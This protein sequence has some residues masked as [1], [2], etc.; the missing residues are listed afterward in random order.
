MWSDNEAKIDLLNI[1][2]L[3]SGVTSIVHN[4]QLSPVTIGVFGDWGSGKSSILRMVHKELESEED[5][6]CVSFNG[7]LFEGYEDAK[8]ALMG[9]ILEELK[10]KG[11]LG[12]KAL[13]LASKLIKRVNWF[14]VLGLAGKGILT[15]STGIPA[16]T[17]SDIKEALK[18]T[19]DV[20]PEKI[21]DLDLDQVEKVLKAAPEE[22]ARQ[23]IREFH[24]DFEELIKQSK[25]K[26]LVVFIDDLDRCLP[27]TVIDTL[28]AIRLFLYVPNTVF[29]IAADEDLVRHAVEARFPE[30]QD[31]NRNVGRDY[32]EKLVQVP[33]RLPPLGHT[34]ME[35]YMSLLFIQLHLSE[36]YFSELIEQ[37]LNNSEDSDQKYNYGFYGEAIERLGDTLTSELENDLTLVEQIADVLTRGFAG[38]PRQAKRFLNTLLLRMTMAKA[39][40]KELQKRVLAKLMLLEYFE[41]EIFRKL[42]EWQ[43]I[44]DG[45]PKE[46]TLLE[47][48]VKN[49][50]NVENI[51]GEA[52]DNTNQ[53]KEE[54]I[55]QDEDYELPQY[56]EPWLN[57]SWLFEWLS[58][59]PELTNV[60]LRPYFHIAR[61]RLN[62]Q[63]TPASRL[64]QSAQNVL[65]ALISPSSAER[66]NG[67]KASVELQ[68]IEIAVLTQELLQRI[69]RTENLST[70][71]PPLAGLIEFLASHQDRIP[72][73]VRTLR[74]LNNSRIPPGLSPA[75]VTLSENTS[76]K[77][78]VRD[79][80]KEWAS[81]SVG[82][83]AKSASLVLNRINNGNI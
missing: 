43:G 44:Q 37:L 9:T 23:T 12:R 68:E 21:K 76:H 10:S 54:D 60:D 16:F 74:I 70:T 3:V 6:L 83:L 50:T 18:S 39:Q 30:M 79:L 45:K 33:F 14:R 78:L 5:V 67:I 20:D 11:K 59:S 36:E 58:S 81:S 82:P 49:S 80:L 15:F 28:E 17:P 57:S 35:R 51:T 7:W 56:L 19:G 75:L 2:H 42:S 71:E 4:D 61:E 13:N 47:R 73:A 77:A 65:S 38:N 64:S 63:S 22:S 69:R 40:K 8:A 72:D 46:L 48:H 55:S 26:K 41:L 31:T 52:Q 53:K 29:I 1:Q 66:K 62:I 27:N 24:S 25:L 32:L 34:E